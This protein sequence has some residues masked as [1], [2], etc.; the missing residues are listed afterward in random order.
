MDRIDEQIL[1]LLKGNA[2]MSHQEL[3][4]KLGISR[5]AAMKRV[6]KLEETGIIK[7]YNTYIVSAQ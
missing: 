5:V 1:D 4:D 6:R 3:G 7:G 2:R